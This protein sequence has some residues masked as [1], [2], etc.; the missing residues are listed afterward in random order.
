MNLRLHPPTVW[1]H[2][3]RNALRILEAQRTRAR[4]EGRH[5]QADALSFAELD[6]EQA[7]RQRAAWL[8]E[9]AVDMRFIGAEWTHTQQ[10]AA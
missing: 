1:Q 8:I 2:E 9:E 10:A 7:L 5:A 3:R 6:V 4:R